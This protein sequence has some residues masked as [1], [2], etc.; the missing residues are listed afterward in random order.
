MANY[1]MVFD[2]GSA[3]LSAGL[4]NDGFFDR[5][6][7]V[8]AYGGA[9]NQITAVG[10]E[11]LRIASG[12]NGGGVK[13]NRPILEGA[14][15]D[16]DGAKAL[17]SALLER[18]CDYRMSAFSRYNVSCVVPCCM[19]SIDKKTIETTFLALG[20]KQVSFV[21]TPVADSFKLFKDFRARQ[22][23]VMDIGYDCTD[24][25]A[26]CAGGILS[27]CTAYHAGKHLT[28]AIID[29]IKTKYLIQLSFE[30]GEYLKI[31]CA[32]LY[33][34]DSSVCSV[35]GQN[36]QS[37]ETESVN[38]SSKELYDTVV[39]FARKYVKLIQGV[40]A[41]VPADIAPA[42]KA[43][44]IMVCGGGARLAG[45]DVFLQ[46]ELGLPVRIADFPDEVT[47]LSMLEV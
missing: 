3:Y 36:S 43:D 41:T 5:I 33:A 35:T 31:N 26:V 17:I 4:K 6:P 30:Q 34:N 27:G 16:T 11:A 44:G 37:G 45:L 21:E 1:E 15:I 12:Y 9:A 25:A 22:G 38:V 7:S 24:I 47:I 14:I 39:E 18:L 10:V 13:L 29:R 23:V 42:L 28:Q 32:S 46:N 19:N 40:I 20:A 2:M 8:V